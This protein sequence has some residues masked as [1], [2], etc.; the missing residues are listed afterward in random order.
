MFHAF[1]PFDSCLFVL[2]CFLI[3]FA[4]FMHSLHFALDLKPLEHYF[5]S[6]IIFQL[7]QPFNPLIKTIGTGMNHTMNPK[8]PVPMTTIQNKQQNLKTQI[9]PKQSEDLKRELK[10]GLDGLTHCILG[11]SYEDL[12][13]ELKDVID[14]PIQIIYFVV[15]EDLKRELKVGNNI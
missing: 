2:I 8:T 12:K 10:D 14:F 5:N 11:H 4:C 6:F 15:K 9:K 13:R 7:E 1:L 3:A